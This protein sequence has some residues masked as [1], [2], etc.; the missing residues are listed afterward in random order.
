[1]FKLRKLLD[2]TNIVIQCHDNPDADTIACG[3]ALYH[4]LKS[5]HK[6]PRLIYGGDLPITKANLLLMIDLLKIPIIHVTKLPPIELLITVDCQHGERNV[7][8][9]DADQIV[10][11]D[12]HVCLGCTSEWHDVRP[13]LGS[14]STLIWFLLNDASF[15]L[16][17]SR[18]VSTA[19]Y[20][21]L[22]TDTNAFSELYHPMD[23]ELADTCFFDK[24]IVARLKSTN[25]S[26]NEL[27][28]AGIALIRHSVNFKDRFAIFKA[29]PCDPNILGFI[30][31]LAIQVDTIDSCI[32]YT[33]LP[34]GIKYS[35][36]SCIKEIN[37]NELASYI[38]GTLGSGGGH[39]DKAG[40][41]ITLDSFYEKSEY[42]NL[43]EYFL[44]I[45]K[46]YFTSFDIIYADT[47][48]F[49]DPL[50]LPYHKK[51]CLMGY[52]CSIEIFPEGTPFVIRTLQEDI[53][54]VTAK[55][56]YILISSNNN[57]ICVSEKVFKNSY[58]CSDA[59][60]KCTFE[61]PP[62]IKNLATNELFLL[63]P[64]FNQCRYPHTDNVYAKKL[65]KNIKL[66]VSWDPNKYIVGLKN[67][68]LV[69]LKN[70]PKDIF[71]L[72]EDIF[73]KTYL[74]G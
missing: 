5:H 40:G 34:F 56:L 38:A 55:D 45:T 57:I 63:G 30:S 2:F 17:S 18:L 44:A 73:L 62:H 8:N 25:L 35:I 58:I 7:Q 67:D 47:L 51:E 28:I 22:F 31:D 12:H 26:L 53:E 64:T 1:M 68:Y 66:F 60:Y 24:A 11:L 70:D 50:M 69:L 20:Y 15:N 74:P 27:E 29:S 23:R 37:A 36:R 61:Y 42:S 19:L 4:Y 39:A 71:I 16:E 54:G 52:I 48:A 32:V 33:E 14:C 59:P 6:N 65:A 43:D 49:P 9:F 46:E 41:L 13:D 3:Y 72:K 10:V 21:G